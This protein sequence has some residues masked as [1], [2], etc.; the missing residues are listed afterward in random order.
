MSTSSS[1]THAVAT[2]VTDV[3]LLCGKGE[4]STASTGSYTPAA[5]ERTASE[6]AAQPCHTK[7]FEL[8]CDNRFHICAPVKRHCCIEATPSNRFF[9]VRTGGPALGALNPHSSMHRLAHY[10]TSLI[11]LMV[12]DCCVMQRWITRESDARLSKRG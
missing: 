4:G 8:R 12:R 10:F 5:G 7:A 3:K 6:L 2:H 9:V 1:S 11:M